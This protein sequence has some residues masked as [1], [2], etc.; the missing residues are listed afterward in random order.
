M[1]GFKDSSGKFHPITEYKGV[2][3]SRNQSTKTEGVKVRKAKT[4][5]WMDFEAWLQSLPK[6]EKDRLKKKLGTGIGAS[7]HYFNTVVKKLPKEVVKGIKEDLNGDDVEI[8]SYNARWKLYE[9]LVD[10]DRY[11]MFPDEDS[12]IDFGRQSIR[13]TAFDYVPEEDSENYDEW[14]DLDKDELV[15]KII[16]EQS[17]YGQRSEL[18]AVA[19]SVAGYDGQYHE[20][21][22][23]WI[24]FQID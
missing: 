9:V 23:G 13:D 2:R 8:T 18:G 14:K 20:L 7:L 4:Q 22:N 11:Y 21:P 3:K 6:S 1:K 17:D 16:E 12:A 15:E 19:Q 24:A 5:E 10:E